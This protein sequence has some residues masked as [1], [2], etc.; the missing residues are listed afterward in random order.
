MPTWLWIVIYV[1]VHFTAAFCV[2]KS[3]GGYKSKTGRNMFWLIFLWYI[4]IPTFLL[5]KLLWV[6]MLLLCDLIG[7]NPEDIGIKIDHV[8]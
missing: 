8:D 7:E 5:F 6:L 2:C 3:N 1:L 4:I